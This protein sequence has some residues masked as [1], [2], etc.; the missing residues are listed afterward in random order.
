MIANNKAG[1]LVRFAFHAQPQAHDVTD[2]VEPIPP[3]TQ[4]RFFLVRTG[5][6]Q[7]C[8]PHNALDRGIYKVQKTPAN[9]EPSLHPAKKTELPDSKK[10][11]F[12]D[13]FLKKYKPACITRGAFNQKVHAYPYHLSTGNRENTDN[14]VGK[15]MIS[16]IGKH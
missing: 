3:H 2:A 15:T 1:P 10:P 13:F 7:P 6:R 8:K 9:T 14:D 16:K 11:G 4:A 12:R 5:G